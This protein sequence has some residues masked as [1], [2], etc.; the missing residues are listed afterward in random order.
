MV[1]NIKNVR[2]IKYEIQIQN[3]VL[4]NKIKQKPKEC[5]EGKILN[6]KTNKCVSI[7][8]KIGQQLNNKDKK[9]I[10]NTKNKI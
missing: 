6:P 10:K 9:E 7:T 2:N 1:A 4:I 5:P 8:G 3:D